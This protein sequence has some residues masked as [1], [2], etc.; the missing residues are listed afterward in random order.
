MRKTTRRY[1]ALKGQ[2]CAGRGRVEPTDG[3]EPST[4]CL[5]NSCSTTELRWLV[6]IAGM[7]GC[8]PVAIRRLDNGSMT[9]KPLHRGAQ[10]L[11]LAQPLRFRVAVGCVTFEMRKLEMLAIPVGL[12]S[13]CS[14]GCYPINF[15]WSGTPYPVLHDQNLRI[16]IVECCDG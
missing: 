9:H 3:I 10:G 5:R 12:A 15:V 7:M 4:C 14:K 11:S 1:I 8:T 6:G 13:L 2:S 16:T